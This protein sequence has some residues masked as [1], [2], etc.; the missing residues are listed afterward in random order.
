MLELELTS[1][2]R[3]QGVRLVGEGR[4][5]FRLGVAVKRW[6]VAGVVAQQR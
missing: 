1:A 5:V 2:W 3:E 4:R 6:H